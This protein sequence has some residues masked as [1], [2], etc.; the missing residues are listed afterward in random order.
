MDGKIG[1]NE[2]AHICVTVNDIEK[3]IELV[4]NTFEVPPIKIRETESTARLKG[5]DIGKYK[6]KLAMVQI[7]K[8][9][10]IEFLQVTEGKSVE[11]DWLKKHGETIHHIA[12]RVDDMEKE[13]SKWEK[14][15]VRILQ[16]DHG[17]WIYMDTEKILGL[18][19]EL[20][21]SHR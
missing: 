13:A 18:N 16:E 14:K 5:K 8:N 11:Q 7:A 6:I 21:P 9:M 4:E 2:I 20:V 12:V 10:T 3:A 15:G 1:I 17:R 19:V